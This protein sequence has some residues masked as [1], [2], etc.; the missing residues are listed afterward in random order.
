LFDVGLS[1]DL[2]SNLS[3]VRYSAMVKATKTKEELLNSRILDVHRASY[4]PEAKSMIDAVYENYIL[5]K[6]NQHNYIQRKHLVKLLLPL[7][8]TWFED[9]EL[10]TAISFD[11]NSHKKDA[12]YNK[13]HITKT[14]IDVAK[15]LI[16]DGLLHIKEGC[17][18][19]VNFT[20]GPSYTTRIWPS[21]ELIKFFKKAKINIL[22]VAYDVNRESVVL[23]NID[24]TAPKKYTKTGK[25]K[26]PVQIPV[27]YNDNPNTNR[28]RTILACYN[29]LLRSAHID[30]GTADKNYLLS[31]DDY[32]KERK[33]YLTP[34]VFVRRVFNS[35]KF[36]E[37]G[38]FYGAWW[39]NCSRL[40]RQ[41]ILINGNRTV[42]ID[43]TA[44]HVMFL[45]AKDGV[46]YF[47]ITKGRDPYDI[48]VPELADYPEFNRQ[49]IKTLILMSLND[50]NPKTA[51]AAARQ[52]ITKENFRHDGV[53]RPP[54]TVIDK[55]DDPFLDKVFDLIRQNH[56]PI[57][58]Y[59]FTGLA[60]GLQ[61]MDGEITAQIIEHFT[62]HYIPI[63]TVHDSYVIEEEFASVL[64]DV[65]QA[66][67]RETTRILDAPIYK[68]EKKPKPV[69][70][71]I[72]YRMKERDHN[73]QVEKDLEELSSSGG[74]TGVKYISDSSI[75]EYYGGRAS[76]ET[77]A[78]LKTVK[79]S[80][81]NKKQI[82]TKRYKESLL[83]HTEWL[84]QGRWNFNLEDNEL[85]EKLL[86][87]ESTID[88]KTFNRWKNNHPIYRELDDP[89]A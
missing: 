63:L 89:S 41:D 32:G 5:P 56:N 70:K 15:L 25:E 58:K 7:Y 47:E 11:N 14:I 24:K 78:N 83:R 76:K 84:K 72:G 88:A 28:M 36:T 55:L 77:E 20:F 35:G 13:L 29:E 85:R 26:K 71:K 9:P 8:V 34:N 45:H 40:D 12:R 87:F 19:P 73:I 33:V 68:N 38:R 42:E 62:Q 37:G 22:D 79:H 82:L 46:N 66:G 30:V 64:I 23:Q 39:M 53:K 6:H 60:S 4:W 27:S 81:Y 65:M 61:F 80:K 52:S 1:T 21:D 74:R 75:I 50:D 10:C 59:F 51:Y 57:E 16:E 54:K 48:P 49:L 67:F 31:V 43:F 2:H 69:L 3:D 86:E 18:P 17:P 44:T